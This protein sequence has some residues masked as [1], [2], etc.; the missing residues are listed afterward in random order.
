MNTTTAT[1]LLILALC[2]IPAA[3][4][5]D[6]AGMPANSPELTALRQQNELLEKR[7]KLLQEGERVDNSEPL[8][9]QG[10]LIEQHMRLLRL[11]QSVTRTA[12]SLNNARRLGDSGAYRNDN[13]IE[14]VQKAYTA[15]NGIAPDVAKEL[16]CRGK[17]VVLYGPA[18]SD[19]LLS[20]KVFN[21]QVD[22]LGSRLKQVLNIEAPTAPDKTGGGASVYGVSALSTPVLRSVLDLISFVHV[23]A[24]PRY[25]D[26]VL[27][28]KALVAILANAATSE[29]CKVYI[30]DQI[31]TNP[32]N[33]ASQVTAKLQSVAD[34]IDGTAAAAKPAGLQQRIRDLKIELK[35]SDSMSLTLL[36][37]AENEQAALDEAARRVDFLKNRVDW[38]TSHIKDERNASLQTKLNQSFDKSWNDLEASVRK[39]LASNLPQTMED[40]NKTNESVKRLD[41][42]KSRTDWLSQYVKDEKDLALQDKMKHILA[43]TWDQ[44]EG[45]VKT[46]ETL[47]V[48]VPKA[49]EPIQREHQRWE[50]YSADVRELI[51]TTAAASEAYATFR[52]ALLDGSSGSSP[53][54][55]MLR[56]E[57]LRDLTFDDKFQERAGATIVQ[58]KLQ[59]LSG[60]YVTTTDQHEEF[61]GGAALSY[62]QF[63][64]NG[65]LKK[66]GVHTVYSGFKAKL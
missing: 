11:E 2:T 15:L 27:D 18:Q 5:Q 32:F 24:A 47:S 58:I 1:I 4:S 54:S 31:V 46:L 56:A 17:N 44:L 42:L 60:S 57:A 66:S 64:P 52:G 25:D 13:L 37:K 41:L 22:Q 63:E 55:R 40:Q 50:K 8:A 6:K 62:I 49:I 23:N 12:P 51:S 39:Q 30:P 48:S 43:T 16:D 38:V 59:K 34:L 29:G 3:R 36:Q 14:N 26:S 9:T 53:L 7:I 10:E 21:D 61:S 45:A 19:E 20:I 35:R 33:S 28:E 65:K